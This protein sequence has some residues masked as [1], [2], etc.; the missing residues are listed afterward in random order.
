LKDLGLFLHYLFSL[1]S[2]SDA[3]FDCDE[4]ARISDIVAENFG[5]VELQF[6]LKLI[7]L[8]LERIVIGNGL[9]A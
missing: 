9:L 3:S 2:P 5:I 6:S 4:H 1:K 7:E 8:M